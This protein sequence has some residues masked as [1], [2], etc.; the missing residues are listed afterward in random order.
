MTASAVEWKHRSS[1][2]S[3]RPDWYGAGLDHIWLPYAQMKTARAAA[4]G[5][6]APTAAA[7][8]W[9]TAAS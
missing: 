6:R 1:A 9:P 8:C 4:A 5:R 7:S 2:A 3:G